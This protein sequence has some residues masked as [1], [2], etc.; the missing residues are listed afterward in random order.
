MLPSFLGLRLGLAEDSHG[1]SPLARAAQGFGIGLTL[2]AAFSAVL[3][4]AGVVLAAGLRSLVDVVPW[5]AIVVGV[6]LK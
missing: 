2:S 3:V 5:L 4:I 1:T 6:G